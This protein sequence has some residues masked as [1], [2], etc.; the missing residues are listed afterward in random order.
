ME[1]VG[2]SGQEQDRT[3][4]EALSG[5]QKRI[6]ELLDQTHRNTCTKLA[7]PQVMAHRWRWPDFP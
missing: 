3:D 5:K 7:P 1:G 2:M 4:D 6:V